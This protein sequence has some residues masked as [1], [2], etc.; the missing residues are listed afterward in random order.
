MLWFI[1][2]FILYLSKREKRSRWLFCC[3]SSPKQDNMLNAEQRRAVAVAAAT[4]ATA[5]AAAA[6][7]LAAVEIVRLTSTCSFLKEHAAIVV[8]QTAFRGFLA[9][10]ALR[11]LKGLV[12][13]QALVRGQ[14]VRR[15]AKMTLQC[16]QALVRVQD[17]IRRQTA[18]LSYE[19]SRRSSMFSGNNSSRDSK[20]QEDVS[21]RSRPTHVSLTHDL[22][23]V[24]LN[25]SGYWDERSRALDE[26]DKMLQSRKEALMKREKELAYAFSQQRSRSCRNISLG[27]E[28]EVCDGANLLDRLMA[29]KKWENV[30]VD[31]NASRPPVSHMAASP[32]RANHL[33]PAS[34][35]RVASPRRWTHNFSFNYQSPATPSMPK[36]RPL[37]VRSASPRYFKEG[38]SYSTTHTPTFGSAYGLNAS[39]VATQPNYMTATESAKAKARSQSAPRTRPSTPE[40]ESSSGLVKKRLSYH[41]ARASATSGCYGSS[42]DLTSPS[43]KSFRDFRYGLEQQSNVSSYNT[44]SLAEE[45]SPYSATDLGRWLR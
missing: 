5:E 44:D 39:D 19:G 43:I 12:Q 42:L 41:L 31:D 29:A 13:L 10:K 45:I 2:A 17:Q 36:I 3:G 21:Q 40:R 26:T 4:A 7:A 27:N 22:R 34:P 11:A 15:Q 8:I 35:Q 14:N 28:S 30:S 9:R 37:Q 32:Q 23:K 6:T 16:M 1:D 33:R 25:G 38:K 24:D 20:F 18:R